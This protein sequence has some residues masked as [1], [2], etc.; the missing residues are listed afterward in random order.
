MERLPIFD[1]THKFCK[2]FRVD[3]SNYSNEK[4][5]LLLRQS[6]IGKVR[7]TLYLQLAR[8][9]NIKLVFFIEKGLL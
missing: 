9:S 5:S 6:H 7:V 1:V 3:I 2:S 8:S 4:A